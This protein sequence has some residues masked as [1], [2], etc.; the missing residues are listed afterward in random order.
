MLCQRR[1][2]VVL[3]LCLLL[4]LWQC[5][6]AP[7]GGISPFPQAPSHLGAPA[8]YCTTSTNSSTWFN[9]RYNTTMRPL[10]TGTAHEL[11]SDVV[12]WWLTLQGPSRGVQLQAIL[13]QL[14]TVL[15]AP[16]GS[17]WDPNHC[18]TCA[19]VGNSGWLKG[20]GH[21]LR[22]DA[23]DWVLRMNRAKIAGFELD[24]GMRTTHHFMYPE[25]AVDLEPGVHLVLVPFKPLDLQ[26]VASTFSTGELTHTYMRVKQFIKADRNKVLILSPAFLKYIHDNWT[27]HHGR[28]PSTGFI[29]LLFA[30]HACQQVSVFGFGADT[31][32]NWHHYWEK[33][34]WSGAFRRTRVHDA[35]IEF[36]LIERLAAEGRILFHR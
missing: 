29:A 30:L 19:V 26:W 34:R 5:F 1:M 22:I 18:R 16:T 11:S 23:H 36:S 35:D 8:A 2:Q 13:W 21:G 10:L 31:K 3:A 28:Y 9:A 14:F 12:Q 15:P 6:Q 27:Q 17:M 32:G 20:S 25:S 33:N 7:R 24:V 4:V